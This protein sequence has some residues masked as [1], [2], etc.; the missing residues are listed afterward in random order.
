MMNPV[1]HPR[2]G[3]A[4]DAVAARNVATTVIRRRPAYSIG[5]RFALS[6]CKAVV[7][8]CLTGGSETDSRVV[9]TK[10]Q[11]GTA[12]IKKTL[13]KQ[14]VAM[15]AVSPDKAGTGLALLKP[16]THEIRFALAP[17]DA[18]RSIRRLR[19]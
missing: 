1:R 14:Q 8:K 10:P 3:I 4:R 6:I 11:A 5:T 16:D 9:V 17:W 18:D 15:K 7:A 19:R 2:G 13:I 12:K